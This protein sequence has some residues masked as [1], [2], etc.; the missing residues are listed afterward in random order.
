MIP[1][2]T[3]L[4]FFAFCF[5]VSKLYDLYWI[6]P[7]LLWMLPFSA[8]LFFQKP[9]SFLFFLSSFPSF[10]LAFPLFSL[11][12]FSFFKTLF[13]FLFGFFVFC[14]DLKTRYFSISWLV[15]ALGFSALAWRPIPFSS[16]ILGGLFGLFCLI[17]VKQEKLGLAD[18]IAFIFMG[19]AI[20]L[21]QL[22][23]IVMVACFFALGY[24]LF[25][26][27]HLVPFL[28]F[29]IWSC[30]LLIWF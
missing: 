13:A 4:F 11:T 5:L 19:L 2:W 27:D 21:L 15:I 12:P 1:F 17:F 3:C 18:A 14:Q 23:E 22:M 9:L 28:S 8:T 29:F 26:H 7:T 16:R 20:G 10:S 30:C 25:F 6:W 24:S